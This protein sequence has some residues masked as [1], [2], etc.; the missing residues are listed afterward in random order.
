MPA[1][2]LVISN[3]TSGDGSGPVFVKEHVFPALIGLEYE[4]QETTQPGSAGTLAASFVQ[5]HLDSAAQIALIISGGDG[6]IHEV[7]NGIGAPSRSIH[8]VICPQGTANAL[9]SSLFPSPSSIGTIDPRLLS[10]QAFL[11]N[12][13]KP[14][15]ITRTQIF[16]DDGQLSES[17]LGVVVASTA[18]HASILDTAEHLRQ[19]IPGLDRFKVAAMENISRWYRSNGALLTQTDRGAK[20]YN[21]ATNDFRTLSEKD[22]AIE[23]P[24]AYFISTVNVDR[25]EPTF[26]ISPVFARQ[27][28]E[29]GEMDLIV[30]RPLRQPGAS[31]D[32]D[33][34]D[35]REAFS[36]VLIRVLQA[37]YAEGSHVSLKYGISSVGPDEDGPY[38]VECLRS[39]G[40]TWTPN[41]NDPKEHLVCV[42]GTILHIPPGGS[43][44]CQVLMERDYFVCA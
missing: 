38:V 4:V 20:L 35:V 26:N 30:V 2:I 27:P 13:T 28:P 23:G 17:L 8:L 29:A 19:T 39:N 10:L 33:S 25:L 12:R 3:P 36:Q 15:N 11:E 22:S 34:Q 42:D 31:S 1:H 24:F 44:H 40:W 7:V 14:L 21:P 6:T 18:L 37:A 41:S 5:K 32:S 9:F 16:S 43:A